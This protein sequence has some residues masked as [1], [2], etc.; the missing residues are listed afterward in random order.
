[1]TTPRHHP[2]PDTLG[3]YASGALGAGFALVVAAHL[4]SCQKCR[5]D[6]GALQA[7]SGGPSVEL[8]PDA[9]ESVTA[10]LDGATPDF[11]APARRSF[12]ERLPL[13]AK[14]WVAP[15]VW[16]T[17]VDAPHAAKDD[18]VYLLSVQPG[19]ATALHSHT[20]REFCT[21]LRGAF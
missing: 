17:A 21:V 6:V 13:K 9:R 20:G 4:E 11:P 5:R 12:L 1:M 15:G 3:S 8:A 18:R 14:R 19:G 2:A 7:S 16:V 10:K